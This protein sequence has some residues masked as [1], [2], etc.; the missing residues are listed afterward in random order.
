MSGPKV[1]TVK[2]RAQLRAEC[3]RRLRQ[4]E[5]AAELWLERVEA[6]GEA[7]ESVRAAMAERITALRAM[8]DESGFGD[9]ALSGERSAKYARQVAA[10]HRAADEELAFLREDL[11][12]RELRLVERAADAKTTRRRRREHRKQLLQALLAQTSDAATAL[13][14]R[15]HAAGEGDGL[16]AMLGEG[17]AWLS[18]NADAA[19]GTEAGLSDAQRELAEA[20]KSGEAQQS[21]DQWR[22]AQTEAERDPRLHRLDRHVAELEL[23]A[24]EAVAAPFLARIESLEREPDRVRRNLLLDSLLLDLGEACRA[25]AQWRRQRAELELQIA[26]AVA[27]LDPAVVAELRDAFEAAVAARNPA[28]ITALQARIEAMITE[29]VEAHAARSCRQAVLEAL[30][31]LGYEVHEGMETAWAEDGR[32]AL[33]KTATPGYGVELGGRAADGRMQMRAVTFDRQRDRGRDRDI[34]TL[35]C[36]DYRQLEQHLHDT[37]GSVRIERALEVGEVPLKEIGAESASTPRDAV[38]PRER[39]R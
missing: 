25:D 5:R 27:V 17:F 6:L 24:G 19:T 21:F 4:V 36:T 22:A 10:M 18:R 9:G 34:E 13:A 32:L 39:N 16:D 1:V 29:E 11:A 26:D 33:R 7:D 31:G 2:T 23:L 14:E 28:R 3:L 38:A 8:S 20:L 30:A 15:V 12:E 37:G 35:W